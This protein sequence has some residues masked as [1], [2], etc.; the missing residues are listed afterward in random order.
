[1]PIDDRALREALM[2]AAEEGITDPQEVHMLMAE[3]GGG[4]GVS[5]MVARLAGKINK[6]SE[7]PVTRVARAL[8]HAW[9]GMFSA[10]EKYNRHVAFIAAWEVA[11]PEWIAT[12]SPRM[13]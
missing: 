9:G 11:P 13:R 1:M 5:N 2:R 3:A 10:A 7:V 8:T 6:G 12:S 4:G